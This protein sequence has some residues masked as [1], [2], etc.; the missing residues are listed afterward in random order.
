MWEGVEHVIP[1]DVYVPGCAARPEAII[2]GIV[3][4]IDILVSQSG[5]GKISKKE[6]V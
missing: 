3:K 6:G 4:A 2:S 1:V 5:S